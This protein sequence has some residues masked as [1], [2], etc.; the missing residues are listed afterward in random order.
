MIVTVRFRSI[1]RSNRASW[2]DGGSI[3][4]TVSVKFGNWAPLTSQAIGFSPSLI[5]TTLYRRTRSASQVSKA[6]PADPRLSSRTS[7]C[8]PTLNTV[9]SVMRRSLVASFLPE[10]V[11]ARSARMGLSNRSV[12]EART[13]KV[14]PSS[15]SIFSRTD[16]LPVFLSVVISCVET[17]RSATCPLRSTRFSTRIVNA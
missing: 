14:P 8:S 4:E 15:S 9:R 7:A 1:L 13:T 11:N 16:V 6:V 17:S 10:I 12:P 2:N 3:R 5:G